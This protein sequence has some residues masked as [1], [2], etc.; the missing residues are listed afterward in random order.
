MKILL[1][2]LLSIPVLVSAQKSPILDLN[3]DNGVTVSDSNKVEAWKNSVQ[4]SKLESFTR[5]DEGRK[6]PGSGRPTIKKNVP[7][8]NDHNTLVFIKQE[9]LNR[10]DSA[11]DELIRG[12]GFTWLVILKP[13]TQ[14][15]Q[16]KDVNTFFG[17]LK[18]GP[19]NEGFWA[20][21]T[22]DNRPW[23]G[24]R[25]GITFGRWDHNNPMVLAKEVLD[26][27]RYYL[28][29][30]RMG[31]GTDTVD[32]ELFI[33]DVS[34]TAATAK[35]PVNTK[36]NGSMLAIGQERD[37]IEHP[38]VESF[39]GELSRFIVFDYPLTDKQLKKLARKLTRD[40]KI[41]R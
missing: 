30:G 41:S 26:T 34:I 32:L 25:N 2:L 5:R 14:I 13:Y 10:N 38:G 4:N 28:L 6:V 12:N 29:A 20:G 22:D 39:R 17:S 36:A 1:M 15:G 35:I 23:M 9:L 21:F 24:A 19:N 16:L 40:Y 18:N 31:A 33:N 37:A 11:C 8:I 3:A 7:E 27:T